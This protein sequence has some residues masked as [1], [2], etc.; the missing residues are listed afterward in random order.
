MKVYNLL[1]IGEKR[2]MLAKQKVSFP[3]VKQQ[4]PKI[5]A[6]VFRNR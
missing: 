2:H 5:S 1:I 4:I 3:F 6:Q